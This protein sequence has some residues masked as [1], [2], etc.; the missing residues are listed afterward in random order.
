MRFDPAQLETLL[1]IVEEGTFDAAARRLHLTPS[2]VSQRVRA[3]EGAAGQVLLRRTTPATATP[4]GEPLLRLARQHRLLE[5]EAAA[6]LGGE[7]AGDL[8]VAVNADSLATWFRPVLTTVA[9]RGQIALRLSIEDQAYSHELLQRG[10]VL[11][12]VTSQPDP[13]QGCTVEP[14]GALRY[15]PAAAPDLIERHRRG[16]R[17][18]RGRSVDRSTLPMVVFNEKDH[19]QDEVLGDARPPVVHRVPST[20]DF[21]EAIRCGLGWGMLPHGQLAAG[22]ANGEVARLPGSRPVDVPLFWQRWRLGSDALATLTEDVRR[23]A[24]RG[25]RRVAPTPDRR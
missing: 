11:A 19:L 13:V 21:Y 9:E 24:R 14:L 5:E 23:A 17:G 12:A 25:L 8:A 16:R 22:V 7:T 15:T 2:A 3:L 1:A 10:E 6:A 4:A 18:R 20:A